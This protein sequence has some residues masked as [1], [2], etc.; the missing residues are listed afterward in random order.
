MAKI[1]ELGPI[2]GANTRSE[3][4]F[5]IVN[6]V[7]G[8]DG[9]KNITRK[10]LVQ[11]IQ[12]EIFDRIT[13]TG[14]SISGVV[15]FDSVI[16][17]VLIDT[18]D[19]EDSFIIRT[20][21][22][23]GSLRN[24][25]GETLE[26][27][28]SDYQEGTIS[29][30]VANTLTITQS[31]YSDGTMSFVVANNLTIT[32]SDYQDGT[33][34][35]VVANN[36]TIT[37]S[38]YQDGTMSQVVANNLTITESDYQDG[39]MSNV[40]A[41]NLTIT[42]SDYQDGTMSDVVANNLTI[43]ES[44]FAAGT[45]NTVIANT[46][47]ITVSDF[48]QGTISQVI[49]NTMTITESDYRQGTMSFVEANNLIIIDSDFSAGTISNTIANTMV[50]TESEFNDS[51]A[52][53]IVITDSQFNDG[54]ANNNLYTN[55]TLETG[56][57]NN[58]TITQSLFT[59]GRVD[60]STGN[61]NILTNTVLETGTAN[62]FAITES[63]FSSGVIDESIF[64]DGE[65]NSSLI[66]D[67]EMD[68]DNVFDPSI[69]EESWFAL[70]NAKTGQTERITYRQFFDE[71]SKTV[72]SALKVHVDASKGNDDYPGTL[73]QP[74]KTLE[75]A[76]ELALEKAGGVYDRND[77]NN[78]VH[79]SVGP[80]TYYTKGNLAI[81]DDCSATSTS[82][83]YA[84]VIEALPGYENNNCWL[85]GSGCYLQ[86]FSYTNWKVDNFDYPEGG[87]AVAYRPG[88]KLR[89]S[90][91][92]RDS[93]QLSNFLRADVE[94]PLNP[95]NTKG[96]ILDLGIE[97]FLDPLTVLGTFTV[98]D[99]CEFSGGGQGY[100]SNV[101]D[102]A[103][104]NKVYVRNLKNGFGYK[105]GDTLTT[106]G[107]ASG[108]VQTIGIDDFP[109]PLVG[110]GGGCLLADRRVLDPDSLYTY[111]LCFG[112]TPRTQNGIGYVA[113]D[114]A[115]VNGIGSLSIF[116][117]CAFY[118]L[119]GGQ[120]TLNNSGSQFGDISMRSRGTTEFF[121]PKATSATIQGDI[122]FA[123]TVLDNANTI[124][125]EVVSNLEALGYTGYDAA[126]CE[127]DSGII[128]E[129]V[130]YD[131]ALDSNY[132]SRLAGITYRSP[133]SYIVINDQLAPTLGA[134]Q[135]LQGRV[136]NIFNSSP[137]PDINVRANY[138]FNELFNILEYGE[139]YATDIKFTDTGTPSRTNARKL[140]QDNKTLIQDALFDWIDNNDDFF[141]YDSVKCRRD[142][143]EYIIP[144]VRYDTMLE[145]NYNTLTAA[146]AY[147]M[148]T[149]AKVIQKQREETVS[150]YTRLKSQIN[151]AVDGISSVAS[152]RTDSGMDNIINILDNKGKKFTPTDFS[153][154]PVSGV[155][156]IT[157]GSHTLQVG[158]KITIAP[159]SI[160]FT[161]QTDGNTTTIT[162]PREG[163]RIF[164]KPVYIDAVTSST[165]TVQVGDAGG[166]TGAHTFVEAEDDAITVVGDALTFSDNA[167]IN[168]NQRNARKQLQANRSYIQDHL[169]GW[170]ND[171]Y[172]TYDANKCRRDQQEYIIP[173]VTN[174]LLLGT[175]FNS[176][177]AGI[178]YYMN[179]AA[180]VI[181][182]QQVQTSGAFSHLKSEVA[183]L[184]AADAP[185]V[186]RTNAAFD[187]IIDILNNGTA[188]A[189][190][191]VWSDPA[192]SGVTTDGT[193]A[194]NQLQANREFIKEEIIAYLGDTYFTFDD[195]KCSRDTGLILQAVARDVATGSNYNSI[196]AGLAYR[197][198]N[199]STSLVIAEQLTETVGAITYLKG[200]I[201]AKLTGAALT[202]SNA[203]FDELI[204]ILN[205]GTGNADPI[206]FGTTA[207]GSQE[208]TA[209]I[210][211]QLNKTFL[212]K[213]VTA[214]IAENYPKLVYDTA[215]CERDVGYIL[216]SVSF[217]IQNGSNGA[218]INNA[219]LYFDNA[220]A[221]LPEDQ[222]EPTA[223]AFDHLSKVAGQVVR[224]EAV[225]VTTGNVQAQDLTQ[226]D[227][228]IVVAGKVRGLIG[229]ISEAIEKER[230]EFPE[231][232]EPV[233]ESTTYETAVTEING[234]TQTLQDD[235]IT[236]IINTYNG[237]PYNES[238]C[239]RDVGLI[240]DAASK[241]I[242]YG[243]NASSI[244]AAE[245]Y[246]L[247]RQAFRP[248]DG[249]K[250]TRYD[251][252]LPENQRVQTKAAFVR[253]GVIVYNVIAGLAIPSPSANNPL[254]Q[255]FGTAAPLGT[256][257]TAQGL[258]TI[259]SD[260]IDLPYIG[261][262]PTLVSPIYDPNKTVARQQLQANKAFLQQEMISFLDNHYFTYDG[263]K[264]SRD[265]GTILDAV[266]RDV[267]TGSNFNSIFAGLAYRGG[268]AG[269]DKVINE[270][271]TETVGAIEYVRDKTVNYIGDLAGKA[272]A[273]DAFDEIID[274]MK[275]GSSAA[276][277]INFGAQSFDASHDTAS[278]LIQANK[279]F[280][281]KELTAYLNDN[282][283]TYDNEKCF[284][285]V[286]LILDAVQLDLLLGTNFNSIQAGVA[287]HTATAAN[288]IAN[289]KSQTIAAFN[290]LKR[291]LLDDI[292][293]AN[294]QTRITNSIDE[295]N[296]IIDNGTAAANALVWTDP[297]IATERLYARQQLQANRSFIIEE[298]TRWIEN[299]L[300]EYDQVKCQRDIGYILDA[301]RRDLTLGTDHNTITAGDAYL[302][303]GS[304]YVLSNQLEYTIA[305]INQAELLVNSI[306][307]VVSAGVTGVVSTLFK[308]VTDVLN[309]TVTTYT[310][311]TYPNSPS[312]TYQTAD[313]IAA[314]DG[315]Q[316]NRQAIQTTLLLEI[317]NN[318]PTHKYDVADCERD[319]G[320]IIDALSHDI[321]YGG[322]SAIIR[323]ADAYFV[324]TA[325]QL[326]PDE[327]PPTIFAYS[328]LKEIINEY[329]T[330]F[331]EQ[332][333]I[334][335]LL[336]I[337]IDV[338]SAGSVAGLPAVVEP[339]LTGYVTTVHDDIQTSTAT[340]Q[341]GVTTFIDSNYPV[342]DVAACER[343]TGYIIDAISHDVQYGGNRASV[344]AAKIYF[345]VDGTNVLPLN[346][347]ISTAAAYE[348]LAEVMSQVV[349]ETAVTSSPGVLLTQDV[350]GNPATATEA[351]FVLDLGTMFAE[352][353]NDATPEN[354]PAKVEPNT[355][356]VALQYQTDHATVANNR[357]TYQGA[358]VDFLSID[359]TN[360]ICERDL[361]YIV[362]AVRRDIGLGTDHN[363][364]TA[365]N[366]YLRDTYTGARKEEE[367]DV[368]DQVRQA[369]NALPSTGA[370]I[371][372][373]FARITD[374]ISGSITTLQ[375]STFPTT[376]GATYQTADRIAAADAIIANR[377]TIISELS[378]WIQTNHPE[379]YY[380][381][382]K[383]TR[384][385]GYIIDAV[386]RDLLLGTNHNTITAGNA[387]LRPNS[388][389]PA[390]DQ[391]NATVA[392]VNYARDLVQQL[393][394]VTSVGEIGDLFRNVTQFIDGTVTTIQP[395]FFPAT[396]G[397]TYQDEDR[398]T[399]VALIAGNRGTL[400]NDL[401]AWISVTYPALTYD[402]AK[403]ERDTGFIIDGVCHDLL[404]GGNSSSRL[405]AESYFEG[406]TLLLGTGEE[407]PTAAAFTTLRSAIADLLV[408][409]PAQ[410][411]T[412]SNALVQIIIDV[413]NAGNLTGLPATVEINTT[414]L[415]TTEFDEI[416]TN[417]ATVISDTVSWV[418]VNWP[419][420]NV[421]DCERDTGFILDS[422]TH[423]IK[424][425]GNSSSRLS[426]IAY[427]DGAVSQLGSSEE[428]T[429]SIAAY[430]QLKTI[431]NTYVVTSAEQT[432][433]NDLLDIVINA[434]T[435]GNISSIPATIEPDFTG[436]ATAGQATEIA[437]N[438][439]S[440]ITN[441][442][443]YLNTNYPRSLGYNEAKCERDVGYLVDA[444]TWDIKHNSNAASRWDA[445]MYFI[446]ATSV[447]P[448]HQRAATVDGFRHLSAI[449]ESIARSQAV[450]P[451]TGNSET[452]VTAGDA[453]PE[454]AAKV[455]GLFDITP[456]VIAANSLDGLPTL[457]EPTASI[458]GV[459]NSVSSTVISNV[460]PELQETVITWLAENFNGLG[461]NQSKC[462]RDTGFIVD[463][464]S[465]DIQ[466]GGNSATVQ[467]AQIY[468][469]NAINVL[470][471]LQRIPTKRAFT[472]LARVMNEITREFTI[473]PSEGNTVAQDFTYVA[474]NPNT[475]DA[476]EQLALIVATAAQN[477]GPTAIPE[478]ID[479]DTSWVAQTYIDSK[480]T[481][482][483]QIS[484]LIDSTIVYIAE[485]LN[486]LGYDEKSCRRDVGFIVDAL[487]HDIQYGGNT[488]TRIN[489][490]IYFENGSSVLSRGT[491]VQ[492]AD[493]YE[494]LGELIRSVIIKEDVQ[495]SAYTSTPQNFA[496]DAGSGV[497]GA[498]GL[499]LVRIIEDCI[500]NETIDT[501]PEIEEPDFSWVDAS[502]V[503]AADALVTNTA[504]LSSD[505]ISWIAKEFTVLD[506]NRAKCRRDVE[507]LVDAMSYDMNYDG[508][509]ASR[510]NIEF[511]Y[512]NNELRLPEDQL[513]A[514]AR[515][516][517]ELGRIAS[518]I[519]TGD[520]PNQVINS[521]VGGETESKKALKIGQMFYETLIN[522]DTKYLDV[523]E[524]PDLDWVGI[525]YTNA[526]NVLKQRKIELSF[527]VVKYVNA[528]YKY[529]DIPLTRRDTINF[530]TAFTND[531]LY[532]N[533]SAGTTGSQQATRTF[534]ASFFDY[535]GDHVFPVFNSNTPY[536]KFKGTK[537]NIGEL[538]G[539]GQALV[540]DAYIVA[541][542]ISVSYYKGDIYYWNGAI[543][544]NDGPNN[545]NLLDAFVSSFV[546]IRDV[547]S[548][549]TVDPTT[550]LM[551]QGLID[552]CIIDN[553]L[554]PDTLVF[555]SLVE[556]IAHQFNGASAGVNRNAL[557]LNFRN[558]GSAISALASVLY[559]DGG[560]VRWSG[561][562]ELNNQYFARGLR[563]NGRT[564]R[565]EGR[566]FTSS[567][568]KLARRAS[569]SRAFV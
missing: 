288:T 242:E 453:G 222:R 511:Y 437:T 90:P 338:I 312:A 13:I 483:R 529:I 347:Q 201:G 79:I 98:G 166:Y 17:D 39:T 421:A 390:N 159:N 161:C 75:R 154:D 559:E 220:V 454:V 503:E 520:Y 157:I 539:I 459:S 566:P 497:E 456:N 513:E 400:I 546:K 177:Q 112:F 43:T 467:A 78:A 485:N 206:T 135:Y 7:Q 448:V 335:A 334:S 140:L 156:V 239:K 313:R 176:I 120:V 42:E 436:S 245:Y 505:L 461:Y 217:D 131:I 414:G 530:L 95:F 532:T 553:L 55:S 350:S 402:V 179:T 287:Y 547:V 58:F 358:V 119:N 472:H 209:R 198:G 143:E 545:T 425:G 490:Q 473:V 59:D 85:V 121:A 65:I 18:S 331:P 25:T 309:G 280:L 164:N 507:Y 141:S 330:T 99:Y 127:R 474:A 84:T 253:L 522:N 110:R 268:T 233:A 420:Y 94:P 377:S 359:Y 519:V 389:Y 87:F 31:D 32:E 521:G 26:I 193:N 72:S 15:M 471:E 332:S 341:T 247:G 324:G 14:G 493:A 363:T 551:I 142:T 524:E 445:E 182:D 16:R 54:V 181:S 117:R 165:I 412:D 333:E 194:K 21:F 343:D 104:L 411:T 44:D 270:Q 432:R 504:D 9:T 151:E 322:N 160:K 488:A 379:I 439:T 516:Y 325:S 512:W 200:Q 226:T 416:T 329:V 498:R 477:L 73:L 484:T 430:G 199:A 442:I 514:T 469:E 128:L 415:D 556:S 273:T 265:T 290:E 139:P 466:Y 302:R 455:K 29:D 229:I 447:L 91:Y 230:F 384:D 274:I 252:I 515:S 336:D 105:V 2:T 101:D 531:F 178:A 310:Q 122:P 218:S 487:S 446:N 326:G 36:L 74:V 38:D 458:Y 189:D 52:N 523:R 30:T 424:Y 323:A 316:N 354:I 406:A 353:I 321:L 57:A 542:D 368:I 438:Q 342:Y 536:L 340:I 11:A 535:K 565:I 404:Y 125:E 221:I 102:V 382:T 169:V 297:G 22:N 388:G 89:R 537:A 370:S 37:D 146:G 320:Y 339:D 305:G 381:N 376:A 167:A 481:I 465:H 568:R 246:F 291:L 186:A 401:T 441:A 549:Y 243:G 394:N 255:T 51:T 3:D 525:D 418:N 345:N 50:I 216:D 129:G 563:I 271:L 557:P 62:N 486:G 215:K 262:L 113:R 392:A 479:P 235:V 428:T 405:N 8:D 431:T 348:R 203:A 264:C 403:C 195:D 196:F 251:N 35:N 552:D 558:L 170:L 76:C 475:G 279:T 299:N 449:T 489:A 197:S 191:I 303:T 24:S 499:E 210:A 492:T 452:Q 528:T 518:K 106:E 495:N 81:P 393:P 457:Q 451:T 560:R 241:D 46:M 463:A 398:Q 462:Y 317:T 356:F 554:R 238:K 286:G 383:C 349:T 351:A 115:G 171:H 211:L 126:K 163:E 53:N 71:L 282:Y 555:G 33:M 301:V 158:Q 298:I 526:L 97:F 294:S 148:S 10:E 116:T 502:I 124:V 60:D 136:T 27:T 517:R 443:S 276:D 224:D 527:D 96:T 184:I 12:Y 225:I 175:N 40:V 68:L 367:L 92:L 538:P 213:E 205:N 207:I 296:D 278:A 192:S 464:V 501:I 314:K 361:G 150:A 248:D 4:L 423:D 162:H 543:W 19:M 311:P 355:T 254:S 385:L 306:A 318:Y 250:Y 337:I 149:A 328:K 1:S 293:D 5:V 61:N 133:I 187:E 144:A 295:I 63:T 114:G 510:W 185:S 357:E 307:S 494:Y 47:T 277:V 562:D 508:N 422:L 82:G 275:N 433:V 28:D 180:K 188:A 496:E 427:F 237:L 397:A 391:V 292:S 190:T 56:T 378:T 362:D 240:I 66:S 69:D 212:Q 134:N 231:I 223:R 308:R 396:E 387:Y 426:A 548:T 352:I 183:T 108:V 77:V 261:D 132:W 83:Q 48:S 234:L 480:E 440:I 227:A 266:S 249:T 567:V 315:L 399:A 23:L 64:K 257:T 263:D 360:E 269:S 70:K 289:E 375:S 260:Q 561:S 544:F 118:A 208:N 283:F 366:A 219:R 202:R 365:G 374:V 482:T 34:S 45:M 80:G 20:D 300:P 540:N 155:A 470:P 506:Y 152:F 364:I 380:D 417:Q 111:V 272:A 460:K 409:L 346:D 344:A 478:R 419:T 168:V 232:V 93:S 88:A 500:R 564:G 259:I 86:G 256:A 450:T 137:N 41:N 172:F 103:T 509:I 49:A 386:R 6:L 372:I 153:Y 491:R 550:I 468:F 214:F 236:Y 244:E 371:D 476:V 147:Y 285:D 204:D 444:V 369:I 174:D 258:V 319:T 138:S 569:Q 408:D 533:P 541:D 534:A 109:N 130:G 413:I 407:G 67:F 100:I 123:Q 281:Q 107:G 145:T 304:A 434:L 327:I 429:A 395:S 435:A 373:L 173:A 267:L 410:L 284:R 228:G